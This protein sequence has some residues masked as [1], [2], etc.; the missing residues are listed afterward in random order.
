MIV[1]GC[2]TLYYTV[3]EGPL[4]CSMLW[5]S[6]E[7]RR[8]GPGSREYGAMERQKLVLVLQKNGAESIC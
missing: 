8:V 7:H 1:R 6:S 4:K 5:I 2:D 3:D